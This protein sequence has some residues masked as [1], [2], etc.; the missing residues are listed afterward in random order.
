MSK[1]FIAAIGIVVAVAGILV[2]RAM[3]PATIDDAIEYID[4]GHYKKALKVLNTLA[5][6]ANY[7]D[8]ERIYYYRLKA[9][10]GFIN[11]LNEDYT[12]E[13]AE[14]QKI[15]NK[16]IISKLKA[17]LEEIN[18]KAEVDLILITEPECYISMGGKLY[19]EFVSLYPGSRYIESIDF[20]MLQFTMSK[21][22]GTINPVMEFYKRYPETTYLSSLINIVLKA[23]ENPKIELKGH[24]EKLTE[25]LQNFCNKYNSS[26]E[27]YRLF[28]CK[29]ENVNL[30]DSAG[31]HG[32]ITGK[33]NKGE[34]VIQLERSM[35]SVQIGDVRDYW[36]RVV[37]VSGS[38]GWVFGK[39]L[40]RIEPL[41]GTV[42]QNEETFTI[43]ETFNEWIDSNTPKG[44]QH[45]Y[46]GF[47]Q[48]ISFNKLNNKNIIKINTAE[49]GGLYKKTGSFQNL[50]CRVKGRLL[51]GKVVL[52]AVV[53][54]GKLA[55]TIT[56]EP[57]FV[58]VCGYRIP[59]NTFQWHEYELRSEGKM[60]TLYIDGELV[61]RKIAAQKHDLLQSSGVYVLVSQ[62]RAHAE[63]EYIK[64]K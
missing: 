7:E 56:L 26:A 15:K 43:D 2:Y 16:K 38:R 1:K 13:C 11:E 27:Y 17:K 9:L 57:E 44:W 10:L 37:S 59:F 4:S 45:V 28:R 6:T 32:Q 52:A 54:Y 61:A 49:K 51:D 42:A 53:G 60:F 12:D 39:F 20:D 33:L 3:T 23:L 29:G 14:I 25:M 36:Y 62:S 19:D 35:D 21:H 41:S 30:R 64:I 48:A 18:K 8:G 31:T 40:E 63:M 58:D 55:A 34:F 50:V 22:P 47:A 5:K 24:A 46:A